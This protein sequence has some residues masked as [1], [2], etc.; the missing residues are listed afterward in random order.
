MFGRT[1]SFVDLAG[2]M[3]R[4]IL[5][6]TNKRETENLRSLDADNTNR[7]YAKRD[8]ASLTKTINVI[9]GIFNNVISLCISY[10]LLLLTTQ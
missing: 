8:P 9:L 2:I 3:S 7:E 6:S 10:S 1:L 5:L 4:I